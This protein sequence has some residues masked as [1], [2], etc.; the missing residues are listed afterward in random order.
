MAASISTS[1]S[2]M[3]CLVQSSVSKNRSQY[4][5]VEDFGFLIHLVHYLAAILG[6]LI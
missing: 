1:S 3:A 4:L 6:Y 5:W 2:F